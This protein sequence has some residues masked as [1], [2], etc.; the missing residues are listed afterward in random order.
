MK[1]LFLLL[2]LPL[3]LFAKQFEI[4]SGTSIMKTMIKTQPGD[5]IKLAPGE[6]EETI[7]VN[8]R[9]TILGDNPYTT[10]IL[11]DGR[12]NAVELKSGA[13]IKGVTITKGGVGIFSEGR[14]ISIS[15]CIIIG[16]QRNG[17][18]AVKV[19]PHIENTAIL[20][21]SGFGIHAMGIKMVPKKTL[22]NLTLTKNVKGGIYYDGTVAFELMESVLYKN[23]Y[24]ELVTKATK[25]LI[26]QSIIYPEAKEFTQDNLSIKV[27]FRALKG[28]KKD[29][30][31][32]EKLGEKGIIFPAQ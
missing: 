11:G 14:D 24:K 31:I 26:S 22:L 27:A 19:L 2:T 16:N 15:N 9:V 28:K 20:S 10:K 3:F 21:N 4:T 32:D 18:M 30:R 7:L 12:R 25:P 6:Y 23:G 29:Y 13:S 5:T 1:H 8:S 17:I